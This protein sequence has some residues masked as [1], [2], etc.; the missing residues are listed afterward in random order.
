MASTSNLEQLGTS[1]RWFYNAVLTNKQ[2]GDIV[3]VSARFL[4][5]RTVPLISNCAEYYVALARLAISGPTRNFPILA[6]AVAELTPPGAPP[7]IN[8]DYYVG[9]RFTAFM[10]D[11]N[12]QT[13]NINFRAVGYSDMNLAQLQIPSEL[14]T[15]NA[16]SPSGEFYQVFSVHP[17]MDALNAAIVMATSYWGVGGPNPNAVNAGFTWLP[18]FPG[19]AQPPLNWTPFPGSLSSNDTSTLPWIQARMDEN[20]MMS[21]RAPVI[22]EDNYQTPAPPPPANPFEQLHN[23]F[24]GPALQILSNNVNYVTTPQLYFQA[25]LYFNDKLAELLPMPTVPPYAGSVASGV[26]ALNRGLA[27]NPFLRRAQVAPVADPLLLTQIAQYAAQPWVDY[28]TVRVAPSPTRLSSP[29][30]GMYP[31]ATYPH[32]AAIEVVPTFATGVM[33]PFVGNQSFSIYPVTYAVWPQEYTTQS[34]W[35]VYDG[36]AIT[37]NTLPAYEEAFGVNEISATGQPT[38]AN[39]DTSNI[40]FDLDLTQDQLHQIQQGVTFVPA[41]YRYAK[42]KQG[43]LS[44]IDLQV[45]LRT[46]DGSFVP[47]MMDAGGSMSM[48]LMFT[49]TPF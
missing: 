22:V 26:G 32:R 39:A 47:W 35:S 18:P 9:V 45:F 42:M 16:S 21:L 6:P 46:R 20:F 17:L 28:T 43:A 25:H 5:Q 11:S 48:K 1:D 37:S 7:V 27:P 36:L 12:E 49:K 2:A 41:V 15:A 38:T 14:P 44:N 10:Q 4:E 29:T 30:F 31:I 24:V 33:E 19:V 13:P 40:I 23:P 34:N 3:P 8:T